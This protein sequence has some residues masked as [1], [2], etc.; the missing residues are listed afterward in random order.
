M[1][2]EPSLTPEAWVRNTELFLEQ[3]LATLPGRYAYELR[4]DPPLSAEQ[5]DELAASLPRPMPAC[6]REFLTQG[7]SGVRFS[8]RRDMP[9][10][11]LAEVHQTLSPFFEIKGAAELL[12]AEELAELIDDVEAWCGTWIADFPEDLAIWSTAF[13][14]LATGFGDYL[15]IDQRPGTVGEP[16]IYLCHEDHSRVIAPSLPAFLAT[17]QAIRYVSPG[18]LSY[19]ELFDSD[20]LLSAETDAALAL[21]RLFGD[22]V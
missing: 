7:A 17:W 1:P 6:V 13:P 2:Y 8:Y 14:I 9:Q 22:E 21:R 10:P 3:T 19:D 18:L 12:I 20:G 16:V 15:A 4:V 5:A 11:D